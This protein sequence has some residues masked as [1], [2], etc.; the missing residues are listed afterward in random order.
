MLFAQ[1]PAI[2]VW[3]CPSSIRVVRENSLLEKVRM[4]S[5]YSPVVLLSCVILICNFRFS[6]VKP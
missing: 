4:L 2:L 3:N 5:V 1:K 6:N